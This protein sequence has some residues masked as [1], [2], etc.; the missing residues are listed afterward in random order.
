ML[1]IL[2]SPMSDTEKTMVPN[3]TALSLIG[4]KNDG[5]F[6]VVILRPVLECVDRLTAVARHILFNDMFPMICQMTTSRGLS[7]RIQNS[8]TAV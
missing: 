6:D 8:S 7:G 2:H 4:F 3:N 1:H 5:S